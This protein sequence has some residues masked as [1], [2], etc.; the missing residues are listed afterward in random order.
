M[1]A[2]AIELVLAPGRGERVPQ[3]GLEIATKLVAHQS[4]TLP[5]G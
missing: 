3:L 4:A 5:K 1:A 2:T